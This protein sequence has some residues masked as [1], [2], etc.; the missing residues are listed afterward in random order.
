MAVAFFNHA[1]DGHPDVEICPVRDESLTVPVRIDCYCPC[2]GEA[3]T[4]HRESG[5]PEGGDTPA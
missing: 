5:S 4:Y 3:R 2:C 1:H